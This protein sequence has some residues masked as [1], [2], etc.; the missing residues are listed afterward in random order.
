MYACALVI[1][2]SLFCNALN[3]SF[4]VFLMAIEWLRFPNR[5]SIDNFES[6]AQ[7]ARLH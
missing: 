2:G 7:L 3:D 1:R 4:D 6:Y 5:E